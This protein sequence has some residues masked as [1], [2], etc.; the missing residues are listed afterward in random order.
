MSVE[1]VLKTIG[2]DVKSF[3]AKLAADLRWAKQAWLLV[4]SAETRNVLLTLGAD[5]IK[6]VKD[7]TVAIE[8]KGISLTL[9]EAVLAD[10]QKLIADAKAGDAVLVADL[11]ALGI[12]L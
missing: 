9:D 12:S 4:T 6:L 1:T 7:A 5:A 8:A 11:K 10:I 3:Y 2:N